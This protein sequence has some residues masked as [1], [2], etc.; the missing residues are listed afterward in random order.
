MWRWLVGSTQDDFETVEPDCDPYDPA[1]P[2][3]LI[4]A[5]PDEVEANELQ[6]LQS[7]ISCLEDSLTK[8]RAHLCPEVAQHYTFV[9]NEM[10]GSSTGKRLR[11]VRTRSTPESFG[12]QASTGTFRHSRTQSEP[13]APSGS[14]EWEWDDTERLGESGSDC[15]AGDLI[16]QGHHDD[17]TEG[18][19]ASAITTCDDQDSYQESPSPSRGRARSVTIEAVDSPSWEFDSEAGEE[20]GCSATPLQDG[21]G[22]EVDSPE[23]CEEQPCAGQEEEMSHGENVLSD[24]V[25]GE[26][27]SPR[28][29]WMQVG[30]NM[31][32]DD[33]CKELEEPEGTV[34]HEASAS[35]TVPGSPSG[36]PQVPDEEYQ[37]ESD[38]LKLYKMHQD[39]IRSACETLTTEQEEALLLSP[40]NMPDEAERADAEVMMESFAKVPAESESVDAEVVV[41]R[42]TEHLQS[43]SEKSIDETIHGGLP[44]CACAEKADSGEL[45][46]TYPFWRMWEVFGS[47]A[48]IV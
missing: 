21:I 40:A 18:L 13:A 23:V 1:K 7:Q 48:K 3:Y 19:D 4:P 32:G 22:Q 17:A 31:L 6:L 12:Q 25:G 45:T 33:G 43:M 11:H 42:R 44:I 46:F 35:C 38:M 41:Q 2:E 24:D 27:Q 14:S 30:T 5:S 16:A 47:V 9:L 10:Y 8:R 29:G 28:P 37:D 36:S 20:A 15:R 26:G 39:L 34:P